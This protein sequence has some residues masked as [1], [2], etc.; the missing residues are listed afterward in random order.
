M[1]RTHARTGAQ[2]YI[3]EEAAEYEAEAGSY[4][5]ISRPSLAIVDRD[6]G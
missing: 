1:G 5:E 6:A 4:A 3:L 2:C